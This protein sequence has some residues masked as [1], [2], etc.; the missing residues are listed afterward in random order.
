[1]QRLR[2]TAGGSSPLIACFR[3]GLQ[4]FVRTGH[5]ILGE[6]FDV[7]ALDVLLSAYDHCIAFG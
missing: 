2:I 1:M 6:T 4:T 5:F 3:T 7:F